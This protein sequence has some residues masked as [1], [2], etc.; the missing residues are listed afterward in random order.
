MGDEPAT[1]R[2][3]QLVQLRHEPGVQHRLAGGH[4]GV[5]GPVAGGAARRRADR[6]SPPPWPASAPPDR[7]RRPGMPPPAIPRTAGGRRSSSAPAARS[8]ARRR[9]PRARRR[10]PA[11]H[12][13]AGWPGRQPAG[14]RSSACRAASNS[15]DRAT[16]AA[17]A[18]TNPTL[19]FARSADRER[20]DRRS[21]LGQPTLPPA[22]RQHLGRVIGARVE[23]A[24]VQTDGQAGASQSALPRPTRPCLMASCHIEEPAH[25]AQCGV[26]DDGQPLPKA[27]SCRSA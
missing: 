3:T 6:R 10:R 5:D 22:D 13:R 24:D 18:A 7:S 14:S 12:C 26:V 1:A 27:A 15:P 21:Q 2:L 16:I 19:P 17:C 20:V 8:S 4:A 25:V 23:I 11:N 9:P